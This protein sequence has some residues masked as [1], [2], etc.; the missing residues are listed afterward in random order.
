MTL[1]TGA[2][3]SYAARQPEEIADGLLNWDTALK[4]SGINPGTSADLTVATL[5]ASGLS[6]IR[7]DKSAVAILPLR[8]N[9]A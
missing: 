9:D 7:A 4:S 1:Q 5:F 8:A 2:P 6:A 3:P